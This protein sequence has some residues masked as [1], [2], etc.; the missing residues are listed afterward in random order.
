MNL[1]CSNCSA[2][3]K[4]EDINIQRMVAVCDN[5][6]HLFRF[7]DM[8]EKNHK[9]SKTLPL[10]RP[11]NITVENTINQLTVQWGWWDNA[12][13][14][15]LIFTFVWVGIVAMVAYFPLTAGSY[16]GLLFVLV[17]PHGWVAI[18]LI[19]NLIT[20]IFNSTTFTID[21]LTLTV[22]HGPLPW[23]GNRNIDR[24]EIEQLFTREI[25]GRKGR[26]TYHLNA[27]LQN[28]NEVILLK[29]ASS[30]VL[31]YIEQEIESFMGIKNKRVAGEY[32]PESNINLTLGD[33]RSLIKGL[34]SK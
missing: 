25:R 33:I 10:P 19:Y 31:K 34:R 6:N 8:M 26:R 3:I 18:G 29:G 16:S 9:R 4:K 23:L 22:E 7:D 12:S 13:Y 1:F 5:C 21:D 20:Q 2:K 30:E 28:Q 17:C 24:S 32:D 11:K 14:N 15:N 27:V